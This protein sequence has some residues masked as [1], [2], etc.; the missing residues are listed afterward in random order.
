[1]PLLQEGGEEG[2]L[3]LLSGWWVEDKDCCPLQCREGTV[4][5]ILP[6]D[7]SHLTFE[8]G[9]QQLIAGWSGK[10]S[11]RA[12]KTWNWFLV[13]SICMARKIFNL[14]KIQLPLLSNENN[15]NIV[16]MK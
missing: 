6:S 15:H 9:W 7:F 4:S 1:M 16:T 8:V 12:R 5:E 11:C 13:P 2:G 10:A 3:S 14:A